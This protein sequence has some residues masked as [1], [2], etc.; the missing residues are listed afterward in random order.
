M[1]HLLLT[2]SEQAIHF[3]VRELAEESYTSPSTVVRLCRKLDFS[4][5][6]TFRDALL[7][8][9]AIRKESASRK[10]MDIDQKE[11]NLERL[12]DQVTCR[13]VLALEN[14]KKL[15]HPQTL[16]R[17]VDRLIAA[18]GI[19][20]FGIGSSLLVAKDAYL[21]FMRLN[22]SCQIY[23]DWH[24]Q[25]VYAKN[26]TADDVALMVSYSGMTAEIL[27]CA[28]Q[29]K[30]AGASIIAITRFDASPLSKL[31]D[32]CLHIASDEQMFRS[33]AM[34]SRISQLN[35]VDI[36]YTLYMNKHFEDNVKTLTKTH[37]NKPQSGDTKRSIGTVHD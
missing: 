10:L 2:R 7:Y 30:A 13:N 4:G 12:I 33:G 1:I 18:R 25:L 36:L 26:M 23:D 17:A 32:C 9:L 6:K 24:G 8:E 34:A 14:T 22:K 35:M 27:T 11:D 37:I 28:E 21:K 19:Y 3:S 15:I 31:A 29:V 5:Y 20:L 16:E